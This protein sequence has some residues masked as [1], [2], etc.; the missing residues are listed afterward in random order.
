M[1]CHAC[2]ARFTGIEYGAA[3]ASVHALERDPD[4]TERGRAMKKHSRGS[5]PLHRGELFELQRSNLRALLRQLYRE[6]RTWLAVTNSLG[7]R[8]SIVRAFMDGKNPGDMTLA[9]RVALAS[10]LDLDV[11]LAGRQ[12]V[13]GWP[14]SHEGIASRRT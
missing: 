4:A 2:H 7:I 1:A 5:R 11:A 3:C 6:K 12:V 10:G 9:Q 13:G 14:S 8:R